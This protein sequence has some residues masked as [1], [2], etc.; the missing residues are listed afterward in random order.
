M[1][2]KIELCPTGWLRRLTVTGAMLL[3]AAGLTIPAQAGPLLFVGDSGGGNGSLKT[4]DATTGALLNQDSISGS[5]GYPTGIA[6]GP[7]GNV[8][9]GDNVN[10]TVDLFSGTTGSYIGQFVAPGSGGM[11]SPSGLTFGPDGNLYEADDGSGGFGFVNVYSGMGAFVTQF[12]PPNTGPPNGGLYGPNGLA[13]GPNGDLYVTDQ[14]NGIDLFGPTGTFLSVLIPVGSGPGL[15]GLGTPSGLAFG[16]NGDLY[17]TDE[18]NNVVDVFDPTT[19]DFLGVFGA[20][21]SLAQPIDLAFGPN[22]NLYVTDAG[23]V[24][25]FNGTTGAS[26]GTFISTQSGN[27]ID[28]QYLAF[29]STAPEPSTLALAALAGIFGW[30][31]RRRIVRR[32]QGPA[33]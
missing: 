7:D 11:I 17:V 18:T 9:L 22:G 10:G 33:L 6:V 16:P 14:T 1:A 23:G 28:G 4:F 25:E 21:A 29:S 24:E 26:M 30:R 13:F 2:A 3:A 31:W 15:A 32:S 19:G 5:L 8:Y 12:V 20:T 27:L